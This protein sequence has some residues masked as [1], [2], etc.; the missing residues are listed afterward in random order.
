MS[1]T[2][3]SLTQPVQAFTVRRIVMASS[4]RALPSF[5]CLTIHPGHLVEYSGSALVEFGGVGGSSPM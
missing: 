5:G 1:S 2:G 4:K 3:H